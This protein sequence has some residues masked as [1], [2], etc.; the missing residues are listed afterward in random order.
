M[1]QK[2]RRYFNTI[3]CISLI[4]VLIIPFFTIKCEGL[5]NPNWTLLTDDGFGNKYNACI[6]GAGIYHG[7]LYIGTESYTLLSILK[8]K[9]YFELIQLIFNN[10]NFGNLNPFFHSLKSQGCELWKYN[11]TTDELKQ[12]IG[13]LPEADMPAGFDDILNSGVGFS[14]E[15]KNNLY[16]GTRTSPLKGCEIWKYNGSKWERVISG[17]FDD[18]SN[19]AAWCAEIF[20]ERLYVGTINWNNSKNGYCQIW[21][22]DDGMIWEKM[23]VRGFKDFDKNNATHNI[24]AW[25]MKVYNGFLYVG[26][27]NQQKTFGHNGCQLWK[28]LDGINWTKVELPGGDGFGEPGNNGIASMEIYNNWLYVGTAV[29]AHDHGFEIWKYNESDWIPVIGD[30]VKDRHWWDFF[31][32]KNDGFGD[33]HNVYAYCMLN[34]SG[35]LWVGTVNKKGCELFCLDGDEWKEIVGSSKNCEKPKG[36][37]KHVTGFR[38]LIEYPV[39][40][41]NIVLGT[42]SYGLGRSSQ[43]WIREV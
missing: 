14:I 43:M 19:C 35:K 6:R 22:T 17:G 15:F 24:Y 25:S 21:S 42:S 37:N 10:K 9:N 32:T 26:T 4:L 23:V 34:S 18:P 13:N 28:T 39:G 1:Y 7:E 38:F 41:N 31:N 11:Y 33:K 2:I 8:I 29:L 20:K 5:D 40:S 12:I 16:V 30:D 3:I 27:N 36:F